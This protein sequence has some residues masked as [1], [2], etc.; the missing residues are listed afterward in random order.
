MSKTVKIILISLGVII[1]IAVLAAVFGGKRKGVEVSTDN[2][3]IR[4]IT[5]TVSASGKIQPE[6]EVMISA[7]VSGLILDLPVKEGDLVGPGDLLVG[8][9]PDIYQSALGRAQ[10]AVNT[11]RSTLA[12]SKAR[13][14]Q[15]EAQFLAAERSFERSQQLFEQG[16][17]S[18][19]DYDQALSNFEVSKAEVEAA[20]Q[21]IKSA[22]FS[23][24]SAEASYRE[25]ADNLKRT[26][27]K[28]PMGGT[29]TALTK[30]V[31]EAVLGT[32]M[33]QGETIMKVSD[34][35]SMEVNVEVNE[36][37]IVLV[38]LGDTAI[39]E[40]DAYID[41]EFKGVV[42]EISNTALNSLTSSALSMD[43]V[44]NFSVKVRILP[45]SYK[46]LMKEGEEHLSP[47]RPGMSATV[48]IM[49]DKAE[50]VLAIPIKAVT[51]RSDTASNA[52]SQYINGGNDDSDDDEDKEDLT[53]VFVLENGQSMIRVVE[54]GLQDSKYIEII[55]GLE[56]GDVV[57]SGPYKEV[58]EN[59]KNGKRVK[60]KDS[61]A[62]DEESEE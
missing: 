28:A 39:V 33:M 42:T 24:A 45:S 52:Y 56:D 25:A 29:V 47:F 26:E 36:S 14:L 22:Q 32:S 16:A 21:S 46:H 7:E 55:N 58:S 43:Q 34:L 53:C 2:T 1:L 15:S 50:D 35:S 6:V 49:T 4:T 18:Q 59:L 13:K 37:D 20:E 44:T 10:A 57:I 23:I 8:I 12:S 3:S 17:I 38:S 40:V 54:T 48:E 62:K 51:T 11:S 19:A 5:E 60:V 61:D 30:E 27:L 41:E 31:G 9:N